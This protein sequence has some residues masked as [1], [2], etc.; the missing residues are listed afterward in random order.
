MKHE[1]ET[2]KDHYSNA[3]VQQQTKENNKGLC[4]HLAKVLGKEHPPSF[5]SYSSSR[6]F[7]YFPLDIIIPSSNQCHFSMLENINEG[8]PNFPFFV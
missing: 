3:Q 5:P 8:T 6:I 7:V 2:N 4:L 1:Q